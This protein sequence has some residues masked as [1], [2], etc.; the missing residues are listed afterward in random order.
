MNRFSFWLLL[1]ALSCPCWGDFHTVAAQSKVVDVD[2]LL[3]PDRENIVCFYS[4]SNA[5]CRA[6]YPELQK[7]G[8][9]P[10]VDVHL[11]DV[12]T[13]KSPTARKYAI[14]SVPYFKIY[15][16][17]GELS[18]EGPGAYREVTGRIQKQR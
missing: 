5:I 3:V 8:A 14:T 6:L 4:S 15:D 1:L 13:V 17:K 10:K 18:H 2:S 9:G 7:L 11:V 12:A 16:K